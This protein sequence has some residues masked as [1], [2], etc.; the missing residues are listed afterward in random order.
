MGN[1]L[2]QKKLVFT[3]CRHELTVTLLIFAFYMS[4]NPNKPGHFESSFFW[5]GGTVNLTSLHILRTHL[6]STVLYT[7][8]KQ[9]IKN[10]LKVKRCWYRLFISWCNYFLCNKE[11]SKN[12]EKW[13]KSMKIANFDREILHNFITYDN[14]KSNKKPAFHSLFRRYIFQKGHWRRGKIDPQ[15]FRV[16]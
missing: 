9:S 14:I 15:S 2:Y 8:F 1:Y 3:A 13:W 7:V 6:I 4:F 10:M 11:M 16:R 12:S 5:I